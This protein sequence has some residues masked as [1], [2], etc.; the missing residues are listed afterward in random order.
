MEEARRGNNTVNPAKIKKGKTTC[1]VIPEML[2]HLANPGEEAS[3][4]LE[5]VTVKRVVHLTHRLELN[6]SRH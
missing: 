6:D 5:T 3:Q 1:K 4:D 2:H